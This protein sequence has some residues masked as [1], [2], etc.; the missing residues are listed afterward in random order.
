MLLSLG[1]PWHLEQLRH[2]IVVLVAASAS[3]GLGYWNC[4]CMAAGSFNLAEHEFC[5]G[6][7]PA[8][9]VGSEGSSRPAGLTGKVR[10][11]SGNGVLGVV[12]N[13]EADYEGVGEAAC[14]GSGDRSSSMASSTCKVARCRNNC[15]GVESVDIAGNK[16]SIVE[17]IGFG[18]DCHGPEARA[19]G[20]E[21]FL[22]ARCGRGRV[23]SR[24]EGRAVREARGFVSG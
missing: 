4:N 12:C 20:C 24:C 23:L 2:C 5:T 7:G 14:M 15:D 8:A 6:V 22:D 19:D 11:V 16:C 1:R 9:V 18:Y 10:I 17:V 3:C 21:F 13:G